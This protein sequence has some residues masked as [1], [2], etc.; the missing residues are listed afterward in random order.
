MRPL[1]QA[2][3]RWERAHTPVHEKHP[4][5]AIT[6]ELASVLNEKRILF[7]AAWV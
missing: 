1:L 4:L 3:Y 6:M 7:E 5:A 2:P